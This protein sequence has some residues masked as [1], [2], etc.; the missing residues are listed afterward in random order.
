MMLT[1][2]LTTLS[3][4]PFIGHIFEFALSKTRLF[5]EYLLVGV[6]VCVTASTA[7]LW[8]KKQISDAKMAALESRIASL[9]DENKTQDETIDTLQNLRKQDAEIIAKLF[10]DF[11]NLDESNAKFKSR[12][13]NLETTNE[14]IRNYLNTPIDD[15]LQRVLDD[16]QPDNDNKNSN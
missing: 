16:T 9:Q 5:I 15:N 10:K 12:L 6:L 8:V 13:H 3:K 7:T 2:I 1:L 4:I 11:G 14:P